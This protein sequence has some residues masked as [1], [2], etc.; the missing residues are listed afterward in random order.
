MSE[1]SGI[2]AR[3]RFGDVLVRDTLYAELSGLM[4]EPPFMSGWRK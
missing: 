4:V 3:Y 2:G 1:I